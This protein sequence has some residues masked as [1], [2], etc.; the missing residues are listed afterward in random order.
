MAKTK[1]EVIL[2]GAETYVF[3]NIQ[4]RD[5]LA[6][7]ERVS[8]VVAAILAA[9]ALLHAKGDTTTP[10]HPAFEGDN[11]LPRQTAQ[12]RAALAEL[13][14]RLDDF[15]VIKPNPRVMAIGVT[16]PDVFY[17][18]DTGLDFE[19]TVAGAGV[20]EKSAPKWAVMPL[21]AAHFA[22]LLNHG[23]E[24]PDSS[25]EIEWVAS[26][27]PGGRDGNHGPLFNVK[28]W[29][30]VPASAWDDVKRQFDRWSD[31]SKR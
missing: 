5:K 13:F 14:A 2:K 22:A 26:V 17:P 16:K 29:C 4:Y 3:G 21:P 30:R 1:D 31:D 20:H 9:E 28:P 24:I 27:V 23:V 12:R 10:V 11:G 19:V 25:H 7:L 18:E 15:I 6:N 8:T